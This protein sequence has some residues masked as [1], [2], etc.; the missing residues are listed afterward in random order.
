MSKPSDELVAA[1]DACVTHARDL[2]ESAK[3]VQT[4]GRSNIAYHLATLA[5]EELGKRELYAIQDTTKVTGDP[6]PWQ[7][8]ATLDHEKKL[9]WCFY[10]YAQVSDI[11]DQQQFFEKRDAAA[12]IHSNRMAGLYVESGDRGLSIPAKAISPRQ[13]QALINLADSFIK[14]AESQKPRD[15]IPQAE[16]DLQLWFLNASDDSEKRNRIFTPQSLAKLKEL[17]DVHEWTR[18]IKAELEANDE[19]LKALVERELKRPPAAVDQT[20]KDRWKLNLRIE[21]AAHSIR[22]A[23]LKVWN[24]A[25]PWIKLSPQQG[26][27]KKEQLLI[28][29]TLG[30]DIPMS[31]LW[32]VGFTLSLQFLIAINIATSGFWWWPLAPNQKRFYENIRDLENGLGVEAEDSGFKVFNVQRPAITAGHMKNLLSC[33]TCLPQPD[34]GERGRALTNYLG[35]LTF[36]SLNCIQWRCEAQAF[37]NFLASFKLLIVEAAY[38]LPPASN[39]ILIKPNQ[40]GTVSEAKAAVEAARAAHWGA[41]VSARSGETEDVTIVHLAVGWSVLQLKV[42]SFSRSERMAKWNEALRIEEALDGRARF[43]GA[44]PWHGTG[45]T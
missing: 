21:T 10:S 20:R 37:G 22:A 7:S 33:F 29:I 9:F 28:E 39:A 12:D 17:N 4:S 32:G 40:V 2:L 15:D 35:G 45:A 44:E 3:A 30:D 13:S 1:L 11:A 23:S 27:K 43:A 26:A 24:D 8:K 34:D 38:V 6:R 42:G 36:L 16:A 31:A 19:Q 14:Y 5:L 41:I 18:A 25:V